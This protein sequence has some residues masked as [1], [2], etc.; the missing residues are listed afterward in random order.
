MKELFAEFG[1]TYHHSEAL[2]KGFGIFY[3]LMSFR[4]TNDATIPR[5]EEKLVEA[6][7][8][9]LGIVIDKVKPLVSI[10]MQNRLDHALE[11]RNYLAHNFWCERAYDMS[12]ESG[13]IELINEIDDSRKLFEELDSETL[14]LTTEHLKE[15]NVAS[16]P[17]TPQQRV[18]LDE[19][20]ETRKAMSPHS[21]NTTDDEDDS[22]EPQDLIELIMSWDKSSR[23][24][25]SPKRPEVIHVNFSEDLSNYI[26]TGVDPTGRYAKPP[27]RKENIGVALVYA[28]IIFMMLVGLLSGGVGRN[29][30]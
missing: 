11:K 7:S 4:D 27:T 15:L 6:G 29:L 30:F 16:L 18:L 8:L 20:T 21:T 24:K 26:R 10:D 2:C 13:V 28:F 14:E 19:Y 23:S 22:I 3:A 12:L 1:V 5:L 25:D 9:T 17:R